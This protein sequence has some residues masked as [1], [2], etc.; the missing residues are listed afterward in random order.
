MSSSDGPDS[1]EFDGKNVK[2]SVAPVKA[3]AGFAVSLY[4]SVFVWRDSV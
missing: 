4:F 2:K 3:M 1:N